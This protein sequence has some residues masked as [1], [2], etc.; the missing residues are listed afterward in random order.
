MTIDHLFDSHLRRAVALV[1]MPIL[2]AAAPSLASAQQVTRGHPAAADAAIRLYM[3]AGV[4]RVE[5]WD[6]DSIALRG[7]LGAN[8]SL[9]GGG[10][11]EALKL[12]VEARS[13]TDGTLPTADLIVSVPR[14]ARLWVKMIDGTLEVSGLRNELEAYTVRGRVTV[15]DLAGVVSIESIDAPIDAR[16]VRGDLRVR[17]GRGAVVLEQLSATLSIST[18]SG[19]VTLRR[20]SADGRIETIGGAITVDGVR[21]DGRLELQSHSGTVRLA[22]DARRPPRLQLSSRRGQV[23]SP[24]AR[25]DPRLGEII[26][27]S[28]RGDVLLVPLPAP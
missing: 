7:T 4:L 8:A 10:A 25:G 27:R 6:R 24:A 18:V 26:A 2:L 11:R 13:A 17:G 20:S 19:A 23:P 28:F 9:F 1:A 21:K 16:L 12:G 15:Y 14:R 22:V 3:P 5:V